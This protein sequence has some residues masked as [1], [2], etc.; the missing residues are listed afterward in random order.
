MTHEFDGHKYQQAATH[1]HEWGRRLVDGLCLVGTESVLDLGCGDG[2]VTELIAELVPSGQVLGIDA[3]RG[4]LK[5]AQPKARRNLRFA[6]MDIDRLRLA[7]R[8]DVIFSNATLHWVKNHRQLMSRIMAALRSGGLVRFNFASAG[9]CANF[10]CAVREI[11]GESEFISHFEGF[12]WPWYMPDLEEYRSIVIEAGFLDAE[13]WTEN[14]D[15][16]FPT[17]QAITGWIDQP[18]IVPFLSCLPDERK[19]PFRDAVV[20]RA[21]EM[22]RHSSGGYFETFR[23]LNLS[24][25]KR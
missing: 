19:K 3:S 25:R 10:F 17:Q 4:M 5:I 12:E 22:A 8:F 11:M 13:V 20:S 1:Q 15:R 18:S 2:S 6:R 16:V 7:G 23:R 24:A 14:A 9:N 21:L